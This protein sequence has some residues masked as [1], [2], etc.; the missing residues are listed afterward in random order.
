MA[1]MTHGKFYF[2]RLMVTLIFVIRASESP[3][4]SRA[5]RVTEKAGT[6]RVKDNDLPLQTLTIS[7]L[8]LQSIVFIVL[9]G[10]ELR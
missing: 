4:P 3:P 5:Q 6:D 8:K 1:I 10:N 9:Y 7:D 2:S